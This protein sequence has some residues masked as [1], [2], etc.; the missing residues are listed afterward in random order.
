M[1]K[2]LNDRHM[3]TAR[4]GAWYKSSVSNLLKRVAAL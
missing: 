1:A 4:G 2:A 3:K